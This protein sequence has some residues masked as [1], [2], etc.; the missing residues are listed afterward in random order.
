MKTKVYIVQMDPRDGGEIL[1]VTTDEQKAK[2]FCRKKIKLW[3][4]VQGKIITLSD[5]NS[6]RVEIQLW[7]DAVN[8]T[9]D[10]FLDKYLGSAWICTPQLSFYYV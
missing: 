3:N 1:L 6:Q 7:E 2:E 10:A 9:L 4:R 5:K 8:F